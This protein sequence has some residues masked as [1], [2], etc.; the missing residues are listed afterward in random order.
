[1]SYS[2]LNL[3]FL[4]IAGSVSWFIKTKYKLN[5]SIVALPMLAL[6]ALFDNLIIA[7]G[8]VGYD[9][10]KLMGLYLGLVP[11][12]DFAYTIAAILLIPIIWKAMTK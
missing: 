8:I 3:I 2:D 7:S 10:S 6:T 1:M 9:H 12:E 5:F 4:V 11:V